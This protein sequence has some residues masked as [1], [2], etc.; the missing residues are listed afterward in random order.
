MGDQSVRESAAETATT[1]VAKAKLDEIDEGRR[2][3][4]SSATKLEAQADF[5]APRRSLATSTMPTTRARNALGDVT[6]RGG[7]SKLALAKVR[8]PG[9]APRRLPLEPSPR[10]A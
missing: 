9:A 6:N 7:S 4:E 2:E 1:A 5:E 3:I 10:S 8:A